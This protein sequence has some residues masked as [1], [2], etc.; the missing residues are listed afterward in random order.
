MLLMLTPLKTRNDP[1]A[2]AANNPWTLVGGQ[3]LPEEVTLV[4]GCSMPDAV[5]TRTINHN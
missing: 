4:R 3:R 1:L 5:G 2:I